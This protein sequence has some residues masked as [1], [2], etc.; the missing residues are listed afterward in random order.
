MNKVRGILTRADNLCVHMSAD[1]SKL[2][3]DGYKPQDVWSKLSAQR[4][5]A[6]SSRYKFSVFSRT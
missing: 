6:N 4:A 1:V 2:A 5:T 3:A